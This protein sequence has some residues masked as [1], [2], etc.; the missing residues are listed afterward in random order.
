M[1]IA[2]SIS[3]SSISLISDEAGSIQPKAGT[4]SKWAWE[5]TSKKCLRPLSGTCSW[6]TA[7]G[8]KDR[9]LGVP[10]RRLLVGVRNPEDRLFRKWRCGHLE[11]NRQSIRA[12][13]AWYGDRRQSSHVERIR[14]PDKDRVDLLHLAADVDRRLPNPRRSDGQR[15]RYQRIHSTKHVANSLLEHGP[16]PLRLHVIRRW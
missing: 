6:L 12:E 11:A 5:S 2:R 1:T 15:R 16:R 8:S 13:P 9:A 3:A 14:Q 4:S 10:L 7:Q